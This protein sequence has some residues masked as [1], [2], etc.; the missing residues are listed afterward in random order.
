[1]AGISI[2]LKKLQGKG[3]IFS[4]IKTFAYSAVLSS[5]AWVISILGIIIASAT[6]YYLVKNRDV[7]VDFQVTITYL[8]AISLILSGPFQ[9]YFTRFASDLIFKKEF[10][11]VLPNFLGTMLLNMA[12]GFIFFIP[13]SLYLFKGISIVYILFSVFAFT[14]LC[15]LWIG[16]SL[17]TGLKSYNFMVYSFLFGYGLTIILIA[18]FGKLGLDFLIFSFFAGQSII[19]VLLVSAI[20]ESYPSGG[21]LLAVD[22]LKNRTSYRSLL[23][24]GLFYN[25][26][27]WADKFVFW[28]SPFTG[29]RAFG[30][31]RVSIVYDIP[32]FLAY[33]S[34]VPGMAVFFLKLEGEFAGH[35]AKYYQ[36]IIEGKTAEEIYNAGNRMILS[37]RSVFFD[38][39]RIQAIA[40][41]LIVFM[42]L[43]L[44]KFFHLSYIYIPLFH[45]LLIGTM[46]QLVLM[47]LVG[48]FFYFDKVNDS[49]L[50]S[51]LFFA[52]NF[53]FS[54]ISIRL[55]PYFFGYGYAASILVCIIISAFLMRRF[56]H[57]IHY[58]TYMFI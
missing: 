50:V 1:M 56:L 15:G 54:A 42:N 33:L 49:L 28:F 8:V 27:L 51:F 37:A 20:M 25:S 38:V 35:Y 39:I 26:G 34:M 10:E 58:H 31:L 23:L 47:V 12:A 5:G 14:S 45:V 43:P 22:F 2:E 19:F 29:Y 13:L 41:I 53:I 55:G 36:A 6:A 48:F 9:L 30:N 7:V 3:S 32:V 52:L 46:L 57:E 44:F 40:D 18:L 4:I 16:S 17:L 11:S 21:R 24:T